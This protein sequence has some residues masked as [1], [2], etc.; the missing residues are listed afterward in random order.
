VRE[1]CLQGVAKLYE[2]QAE[3]GSWDGENVD[4]TMDCT[5]SLM[6]VTRILGDGRG[7]DVI[8]RGLRWIIANKNTQGW[9]DFPGMETN[10]ERTCD[11]LDTLLKYKAYCHE[12]PLEVVKLWV[13]TV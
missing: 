5:R 8:M 12:N 9:G 13:Y 4:H 2:W 7:E 6:A 11:G 10:L 1:S 3:D